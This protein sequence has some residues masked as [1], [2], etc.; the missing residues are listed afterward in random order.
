MIVRCL[1]Y[2]ILIFNPTTISDLIRMSVSCYD[3]FLPRRI[4]LGYQQFAFPEPTVPPSSGR[5]V[6]HVALLQSTAAVALPDFHPGLFDLQQ[7]RGGSRGILIAV[8]AVYR[9]GG[10]FF[11]LQTL[12]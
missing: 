4:V 7:R 12:F 3:D 10:S 1:E 2:Q 11:L 6:I 9:A 5:H 8:E